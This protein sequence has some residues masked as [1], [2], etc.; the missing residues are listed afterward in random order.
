MNA[1]Q[2]LSNQTVLY[3][4][5]AV[6]AAS[7]IGYVMANNTQAVIFFLLAGFV[8]SRFSKNMTVVMLTSLLITNMVCGL[9]LV[10]EGLEN[11]NEDD[12]DDDEKG[13]KEKPSP[14]HSPSKKPAR[15]DSP[16]N[17]SSG[18]N[19]HN[20]NAGHVEGHVADEAKK[21]KKAAYSMVE[22][23]MNNGE[24]DQLGDDMEKMVE[25]H[26]QL[27]NMIKT[28]GPIIDKAG[29]LLD[30]VNSTNVGGIGDMMNKMTG[31]LG[32]L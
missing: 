32:K 16:T 19:A 7:L 22:D 28:M 4:V 25:K 5:L 3:V 31:F 24:V 10:K 17:G 14:K 18:S 12:E 15:S 8:A 13:D 6:S 20:S 11:M 1:K 27:E 2:F 23:A 30:K 29:K 9:K 26:E 21:A